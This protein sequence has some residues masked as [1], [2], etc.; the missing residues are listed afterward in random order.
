MFCIVQAFFFTFPKYLCNFPVILHWKHS[1]L[2]KYQQQKTGY[3]PRD[4]AYQAYLIFS[5][6]QGRTQ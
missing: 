2:V 1:S 5:L 6:V 3:L 4:V